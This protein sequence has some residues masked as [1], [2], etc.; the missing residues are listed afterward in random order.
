MFS[1]IDLIIVFLHYNN[2][3]DTLECIT[4]FKEKLDTQSYK[5]IIVD[6]KSPNKTGKE[7]VDIF[8]NDKYVD[9]VLSDSNKGYN[10]GLNVGIDYAKNHFIFKYLVISNNDIELV[11]NAFYQNIDKEYKKSGYAMLGPMIKTTDGRSDS[12]PIFDTWY[13]RTNAQYDLKYWKK[14]LFM[15]KLGIDGLYMFYRKH[16]PLLSRYKAKHYDK[17]KIRTPGIENVRR[18]NI[19]LHGCFQVLSPTFF[20]FFNRLDDRTFM[21]AEE[22][23]MYAHML[24]KNLKT[25]YNPEIVI[26]HKGG[27]SINHNYA[28]NR[29][30]KLFLYSNY[31]KAIKAYLLLLDELGV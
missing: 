21:Y 1:K 20:E 14:R 4:S 27:S 9:V 30:K 26:V 19:V 31:V 25:V 5:L 11:D 16:N 23:I 7:L 2:I 12:N 24:D 8:K 28:K 17:R 15:T 3:D 18:E 22:D 13:S 29:K 6:N 10:G